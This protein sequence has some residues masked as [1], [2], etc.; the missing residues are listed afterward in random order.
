MNYGVSYEVISKL[1]TVKAH[2]L[3]E[4]QIRLIASLA[5]DMERL[6]LSKIDA[7]I[8]GLVS[9]HSERQVKPGDLSPSVR[10]TGEFLGRQITPWVE[11]IRRRLF[12]S[13][14][15]PFT[16]FDDARK[17]LELAREE[18]KQ[19]FKEKIRELDR[20]LEKLGIK[21]EPEIKN[22]TG[23]MSEETLE[24]KSQRWKSMKERHPDVARDM[25]IHPDK[26]EP[27]LILY[28]E[29]DDLAH[30]TGL[31][32]TS[33]IY[34]ILA[35]IPPLLSEAKVDTRERAYYLP[36]GKKLMN[37]AV[38]LETTGELSFKEMR[39]LYNQIRRELRIKRSKS[40]SEKH[41]ELYQ[42]VQKRGQLVNGKRSV[43]FWKSIRKEWDD[44]YPNEHN[45][46]KAS[47]R[48]YG[49][50]I[51]RL[52]HQFQINQEEVREDEAEIIKTAS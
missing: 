16:S 50:I 47:K 34:Y 1:R 44:R 46:W 35:N 24:W 43:A 25:Y 28:V 26:Y 17:W 36:S 37:R 4:E 11:D 45:S 30:I 19:R 12:H 22:S 10:L 14:F 23:G 48:A 9:N 7:M 51:R 49:L 18:D 20:N 2:K 29:A 13:R 42:L 38:T 21:W 52:E 5:L 6:D 15:A 33:I 39:H 3:S 8:E 31:D 32:R 40:F 41:L 27:Y